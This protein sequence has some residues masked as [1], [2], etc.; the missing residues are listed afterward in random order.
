M[1]PTDYDFKW[2]QLGTD[3]FLTRLERASQ[4]CLRRAYPPED[5][6]RLMRAIS[7]YLIQHPL[8]NASEQEWQRFSSSYEAILFQAGPLRGET[9]ARAEKIRTLCG[10]PLVNE[11]ILYLA[12]AD[13]TPKERILERINEKDFLDSLKHDPLSVQRLRSWVTLM[14]PISKEEHTAALSNSDAWKSIY[15]RA[16]PQLLLHY[17]SRKHSLLSE[18]EALDISYS[19]FDPAQLWRLNEISNVLDFC[20]PKMESLA[21]LIA[22]V[23]STECFSAHTSAS[24]RA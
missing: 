7:K 23:A 11:E 1:I 17:S 21:L 5:H 16:I 14:G 6:S 20:L 15:P 10:R 4:N 24:T 9:H 22:A 13:Q 18:Q 2:K 12:A 3:E 19:L 8:D